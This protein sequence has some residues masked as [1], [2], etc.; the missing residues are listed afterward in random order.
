MASKKA[1]EFP[2]D[3]A[4]VLDL[5][6]MK[7]KIDLVEQR[8]VDL[9]N[10]PKTSVQETDQLKDVVE[11]TKERQSYNNLYAEALPIVKNA[12]TSGQDMEKDIYF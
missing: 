5:T 8:M 1:R 12:Y 6:R 9:E 4:I 3:E 2:D 10:D 7:T 11:K